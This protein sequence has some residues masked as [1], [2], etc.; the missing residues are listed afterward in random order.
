MFRFL[1]G[2]VFETGVL[3]VALS[4]L[5]LDFRFLIMEKLGYFSF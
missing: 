4:V 3:C 5:E 2:W 1:G